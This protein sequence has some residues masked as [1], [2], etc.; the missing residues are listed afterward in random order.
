MP[1]KAPSKPHLVYERLEELDD[2]GMPHG[3]GV[4]DGLASPGILGLVIDEDV[5]AGLDQQL[6]L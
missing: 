1:G 6:N 3:P 5:G 2:M 4:V